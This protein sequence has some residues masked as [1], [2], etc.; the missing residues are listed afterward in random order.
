[1]QILYFNFA[2]YLVIHTV[3]LAVYNSDDIHL[4]PI[5]LPS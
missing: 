1:M 5:G 3:L 4:P 2:L